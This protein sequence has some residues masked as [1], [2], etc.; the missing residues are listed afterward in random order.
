[1]V[2]GADGVGRTSVSPGTYTISG[3]GTVLFIHVDVTGRGTLDQT[4]G[5]E[6]NVTFDAKDA[7]GPGLSDY[8]VAI[9]FQS[10]HC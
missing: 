2:T 3:D 7:N 1:V 10:E 6:L 9:T 8:E 4:E 5:S